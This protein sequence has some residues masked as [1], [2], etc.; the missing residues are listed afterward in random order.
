[1]TVCYVVMEPNCCDEGT[2]LGVFSTP[3]GAEACVKDACCRVDC[4]LDH[5]LVKEQELRPMFLDPDGE[6]IEGSLY[7]Q[8]E[9][10]GLWLDAVKEWNA[11]FCNWC[12]V[13]IEE[14]RG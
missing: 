4:T 13:H 7:S 11:A 2:L 8:Y 3:A 1:M 5:D 9:G 6:P 10:Y 12:D 14:I